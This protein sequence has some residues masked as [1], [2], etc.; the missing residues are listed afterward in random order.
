MKDN[1]TRIKDIDDSTRNKD[2]FFD[3]SF[4]SH[5]GFKTEPDGFNVKLIYKTNY[6]CLMVQVLSMLTKEKYIIAS[7][8]VY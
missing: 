7:E 5:D 2:F 6:R 8:K 3:Y 1:M 4:W